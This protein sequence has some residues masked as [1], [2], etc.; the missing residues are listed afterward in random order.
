M[1]AEL[2]NNAIV[3]DDE[4]DVGTRTGPMQ[5]CLVHGKAYQ[6]T[7]GGLYTLDD[8]GNSSRVTRLSPSTVDF[9]NNNSDWMT[10]PQKRRTVYNDPAVRLC[11]KEIRDIHFDKLPLIREHSDKNK[12]G[13]ILS[14]SLN[15]DG[16][17]MITA[18][19]TDPTISREIKESGKLKMGAFSIG[20]G[21]KLSNDGTHSI[22]EK[23]I[24][25]I[26]LVSK[27]LFR[28]CVVDV[29]ASEQN[30]EV[31][32]K[33]F[34]KEFKVYCGVGPGTETNGKVG[35]ETT[36]PPAATSQVDTG[37]TSNGNPGDDDDDVMMTDG[38]DN[39][40]KGD[41]GRGNDNN[42]NEEENNKNKNKISTIH[43]DISKGNTI[44]KNSGKV[45]ETKATAEVGQNMNTGI[46]S[47]QKG[48]DNPGMDAG[49]MS[50][51]GNAPNKG[52]D[53]NVRHH[54]GG[55]GNGGGMDRSQLNKDNNPNNMNGGDR[56][57]EGRQ[58]S[59]SSDNQMNPEKMTKSQLMEALNA[60]KR[61][62]QE[63]EEFVNQHSGDL[64]ELRKKK[65]SELNT[66][67]EDAFQMMVDDEE[68]EVDDEKMAE[69]KRNFSATEQLLKAAGTSKEHSN[70]L[71]FFK[72]AVAN[73]KNKKEE[74]QRLRSELEGFKNTQN[75]DQSQ[76]PNQSNGISS[77][78]S[79]QYQ[80]NYYQPQQQQQHHHQENVRPGF[81]L[82][83]NTFGMPIQQDPNLNSLLVKA[84]DDYCRTNPG[85]KR[86]YG[87]YDL[88]GGRGGGGGYNYDA[89][90]GT[91][92]NQAIRH[93]SQHQ[94]MRTKPMIDFDNVTQ[95][96]YL[97]LS[98]GLSSFLES[99]QLANRPGTPL[100]IRCS[101]QLVARTNYDCDNG[102]R[103]ISAIFKDDAMRNSQLRLPVHVDIGASFFMK[104]VMV[105]DPSTLSVKASEEPY[106]Y[107]GSKISDARKEELKR[108]LTLPLYASR[109]MT[110]EKLCMMDE[111]GNM[112]NNLGPIGISVQR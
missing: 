31:G 108:L 102:D 101:E 94:P 73:N 20:Y 33:T 110:L 3:G 79:R 53:S 48:M 70:L 69:L 43:E 61:I 67:V 104:Q 42:N 49:G 62:I 29:Y 28:N 57:L 91:E 14:G 77:M 26:S 37:T 15:S 21:V 32:Q 18:S 22:D 23:F 74:L 17:L 71:N 63:Q 16:F 89:Y 103:H 100:M 92:R 59:S 45:S 13:N 11:P 4:D 78:Q 56:S 68:E 6:V 111:I 112:I 98:K 97:H 44:I 8:Y 25:E 39:E 81:N 60:Q 12:I 38:Q 58:P 30:R 72:D 107:D 5:G 105:N 82:S 55:N 87:G 99:N 65:D 95:S 96:D 10:S 7:K 80:Q 2:Q 27:P 46:P 93:K 85:V 19:I 41:G 109:E 50:N 34:P 88:G 35:V 51:A 54:E 40:A 24:E 9:I 52:M 66:L 64:M 76:G 75:T 36:P 84:S 90:H 47:E 1:D 83:S 86:N 106:Q